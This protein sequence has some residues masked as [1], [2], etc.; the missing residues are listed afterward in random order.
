MSSSGTS[1]SITFILF[2][3]SASTLDI[4]RNSVFGNFLLE[5][6]WFKK[7]NRVF[8]MMTLGQLYEKSNW[9]IKSLVAIRFSNRANDLGL[10]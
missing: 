2:S 7:T 5:I 3:G 8:A 9:T 4:V 6:L 1:L 10:I